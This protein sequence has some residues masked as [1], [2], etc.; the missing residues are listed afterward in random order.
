M[1]RQQIFL[2]GVQ[3]SVLLEDIKRG[4]N[5]ALSVLMMAVSIPELLIPEN[6]SAAVYDYIAWQY[7]TIDHP[8]PVPDWLK[9]WAD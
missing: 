4:R 9:E 7:Q 6:L 3:T 5:Q 2:L 1:T 8:S